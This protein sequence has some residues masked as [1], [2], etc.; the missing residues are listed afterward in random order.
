MER[1]FL[2]AVSL[3]IAVLVL[4]TLLFKR[5]PRRPVAADSIALD[6]AAIAQAADPKPAAVRPAPTAPATSPMSEAGTPR[7]KRRA[8]K[9]TI[10]VDNPTTSVKGYTMV[11][12]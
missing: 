4:P 12:L 2:L 1:R 6:S 11:G 8:K 10:M 5:P 3:M 9:I 7:I